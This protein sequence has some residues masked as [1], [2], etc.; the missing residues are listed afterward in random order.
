MSKSI[1]KLFGA[2][3]S[4]TQPLASETAALNY[5]NG[6]DTSQVDSAYKNMAALGNSLSAQLASR[7]EYVYSVDGSDAAAKRAENAVYQSA[8]SKLAPQFDARRQQLETRLQNQGLSVNSAAYQKAMNNLETEQND[9]YAQAAFNSIQA[10]QNAFS[11]SLNNQ[12]AAANF[13]N[14]ARQLPVNEILRLLQNSRSGYDVAMDKYAIGRGMDTRIAANRTQNANDRYNAGMSFLGN[15]A[16]AAASLFSDEELKENIVEVGRLYNGLPVY[17]Y[18]YRG[19]KTPRIGLL[20][21]EVSCV[22]PEAVYVDAQGYMRVNYAA[23][24]L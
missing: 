2:G 10:G 12:I 5:L 13:Q 8:V 18:N 23:A 24:C 21:Q 20:A 1:G 4:G 9:A 6:Y 3:N 19:D 14:N 17:L 7:P 11:N 22:R 15:A 16:G